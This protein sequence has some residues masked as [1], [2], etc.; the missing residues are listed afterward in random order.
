LQ[1]IIFGFTGLRFTNNG[2]AQR[3]KAL[4]PPSSV[5]SYNVDVTNEKGLTLTPVVE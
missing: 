2:L 1:Q 3:Y 5:I 4:L